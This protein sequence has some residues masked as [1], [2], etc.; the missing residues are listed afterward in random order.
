[1]PNKIETR[2]VNDFFLPRISVVKA[3]VKVSFEESPGILQ[4]IDQL[5]NVSDKLLAR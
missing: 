4:L 5:A 3:E 2:T 1:M